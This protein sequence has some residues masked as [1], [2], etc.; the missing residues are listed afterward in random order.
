MGVGDLNALMISMEFDCVVEEGETAPPN[1]GPC[2]PRGN[3]LYARS[4]GVYPIALFVDRLVD[5]LLQDDRVRIPCDG[6]KRNEVS[7]KYLFTEVMCNIAGGPEVITARDFD[8]TKLLLPKAA[9]ELFVATAQIAA[10]HFPIAVRAEVVQC[11]Q[12]SKSVIVD[13]HD[14]EASLP[15]VILGRSGAQAAA[16]V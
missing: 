16:N 11:L 13:P 3:S 2:Q 10:D 5:A 7:L 8:E 9:W 1:P 4:G 15:Q 12:R 14:D 6:Q